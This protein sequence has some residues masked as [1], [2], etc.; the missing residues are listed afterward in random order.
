MVIIFLREDLNEI[1]KEIRLIL[2][3][4]IMIWKVS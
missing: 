1:E 3:L 4:L 2:I